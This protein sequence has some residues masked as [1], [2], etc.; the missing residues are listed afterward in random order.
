MIT[1]SN[2]NSTTNLN[3]TYDD[4]DDSSSFALM[5]SNLSIKYEQITNNNIILGK[6]F[7]MSRL[8]I[9]PIFLLCCAIN[10]AA[11]CAFLRSGFILKLFSM[12]FAALGQIT[13]LHYS[14]L[15]IYYNNFYAQNR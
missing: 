2:D 7:K 3:D 1:V 10:L 9:A 12:I 5:F 11:I 6:W 13:A 15:Y 14:D 4:Y 8:Q